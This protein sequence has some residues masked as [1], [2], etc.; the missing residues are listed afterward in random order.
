MAT[1][2]YETAPKILLR[3]TADSI[4]ACIDYRGI[5]FGRS[6]LCIT[7]EGQKK[8]RLE[9]FLSLLNSRYLSYLYRGLAGETGRV[10]AQVKFAKLKQLPIRTI[11][12]ANSDDR[13]RH[14]KLVGFVERMLELHRRLGEVKVT[15]ERARIEREI[16]ATDEQI[17]GL[18]YELYGLT[19]EE[20]AIV[21][22][23]VKKQGS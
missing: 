3:Q 5:W 11:D 16:G 4:L 17:D 18:V 22:E 8:H 12:F 13:L 14:D 9:Y 7:H 21:E 23:A 15:S 2:V 20:I 6:V 19:D 10:F 1:K